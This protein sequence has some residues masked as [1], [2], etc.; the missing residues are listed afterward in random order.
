MPFPGSQQSDTIQ[1]AYFL[2]R[3][4]WWLRIA[5]VVLIVS[6]LL[7]SFQQ[8]NKW[9]KVLVVL[10]LLLYGFIYYLFNFKF[11]ADKIFIQSTNINFNSSAADTTD[12]EKLIIGIVSAQT[13]KAY[14][15]DIIGY[16]HQ[17]QDSING[18]PIL[19]T[20]CT[21]CRTGRVF[22]PLVNGKQEIFRLVGMDHYNAM[23]EDIS[24]KSWWQQ[25]TGLAITGER[26]GT[27]LTE[28]PSTQMRLGD[29]LS[30]YPNTLILQ[31]DTSFRKDYANLKGY[32]EGTI[33]EDL[34]HR[35]SASW[36]KKSWIIGL[37]LKA[38][39]RAYDWNELVKEK[40]IQDSIN[41]MP[42]LITV[43]GNG[44]SFYG[45]NRKL[46]NMNLQFVE[47]KNKESL[48]DLQTHS[49][50]SVDGSCME[51][52]LKGSRLQTIQVYQEFWHSWKQFHPNTSTFHH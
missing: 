45:F 39:D 36:Q 22:S 9:L 16:H 10:A 33:E 6:P 5:G 12:R 32:D 19:V 15:I 50:W 13:A 8:P 18:E 51:G 43:A 34:E 1:F 7:Y 37:H 23:F 30:L 25:A 40:M 42:V 4:I 20:Y 44:K 14:P 24:T 35:D 38:A 27:Q 28:L 26:K 49:L 11:L 21:V 48:E 17:V 3:N 47:G 52:P 29:W 31:P 46:N 2:H 41:D